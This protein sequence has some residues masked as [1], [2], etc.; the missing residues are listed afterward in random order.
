MTSGPQWK[1][2]E[3]R[4]CTVNERKDKNQQ[5]LPNGSKFL[6]MTSNSLPAI[7]KED[8]EECRHEKT[9]TIQVVVKLSSF[10]HLRAESAQ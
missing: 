6:Q 4:V 7:L 1:N 2:N 8:I 10:G 9:T 3:W 5:Q